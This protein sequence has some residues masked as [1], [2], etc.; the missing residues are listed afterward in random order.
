M[1][2]KTDMWFSIVVL[3]PRASR[4][5]AT[6]AKVSLYYTIPLIVCPNPSSL[7]ECAKAARAGRKGSGSYGDS[8]EDSWPED[9]ARGK[10]VQRPTYDED[11]DGWGS[12]QSPMPQQ[13]Q[14]NPANS[15]TYNCC[16]CT[17]TV[18]S[19]SPPAEC[20][21]CKLAQVKKELE[22]EKA[23]PPV[24]IRKEFFI[25]LGLPWLIVSK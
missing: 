21:I 20:P 3:D 5:I 7:L 25:S 14:V 10:A 2:P 9:T 23:K 16:N 1:W 19:G 24:V 13:P 4:L 6:A 17:I 8:D 12:V 22:T 18:T 15:K 11:D